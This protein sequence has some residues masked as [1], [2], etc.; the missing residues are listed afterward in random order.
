MGP[1]SS[2]SSPEEVLYNGEEWSYSL[3][4]TDESG[5]DGEVEKRLYQMVPIPVSITS[6]VFQ[7]VEHYV[8]ATPVYN[9]I[10]AFFFLR[11]YMF[12]SKQF[13]SAY[14]VK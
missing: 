6:P 8:K 3:E 12:W 9:T 5:L 11:N 7:I 2:C 1:S 13:D 14:N 4:L 10:S